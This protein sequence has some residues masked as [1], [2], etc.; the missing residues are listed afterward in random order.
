ML[1]KSLKAASAMLFLFCTANSYA[2]WTSASPYGFTVPGITAI[3]IN[4]S[5]AFP[6]STLDVSGGA[7]IGAGYAASGSV[8]PITNGLMVQ[9]KVAIGTSGA[10]NGQLDVTDGV[11]IGSSY[12]GTT[13]HNRIGNGLLVQ[14]HIGI[15]IGDGSLSNNALDVTGGAAIGSIYNPS[16]NPGGFIGNS[17]L[18]YP[19]YGLLV[20]GPMATGTSSVSGSNSIYQLAVSQTTGGAPLYRYG[21]YATSTSAASLSGYANIAGYFS[22]SNVTYTNG[23]GGTANYGL[24]VGNGSTI[25]TGAGGSGMD[26]NGI[27]LLSANRM[28]WIPSKGSFRVGSPGLTP[29]DHEWDDANIG[30]YTFVAG[31][32]SYAMGNNN[33][34][35]GSYVE[36]GSNTGCFIFGDGNGTLRNTRH[37]TANNQFLAIA[38]GGLILTTDNTSANSVYINNIGTSGNTMMGIGTSTPNSKITASPKLEVNGN[39]NVDYDLYLGQYAA[40]ASCSLTT[41]ASGAPLYVDF[42]TGKVDY[43]APSLAGGAWAIG[44]N[45]FTG[46]VVP[47][48]GISSIG[49]PLIL[50]TT[51]TGAGPYTNLEITSSGHTG[52]P[53]H[54]NNLPL[55]NFN[56][57]SSCTEEMF[58]VGDDPDLY[59]TYGPGTVYNYGDFSI[60]QFRVNKN[61]EVGIYKYNT[62]STNVDKNFSVNNDGEIDINQYSSGST[63]NELKMDKN[64]YITSNPLKTVPSTS[65][66]TAGLMLMAVNGKITACPSTAS[67][68]GGLAVTSGLGLNEPGMPLITLGGT[69]YYDANFYTS[70]GSG[71]YYNVRLDHGSKL[72][73]GYNETSTPGVWDV[74]PEKLSITGGAI[75][76]DNY[77][78]STTTDR[79]YN[80]SGTLM[81]NGNPVTNLYTFSNGI[82]NSSGSVG[83]GGSLTGNTLLNTT[84][85]NYPFALSNTS[86]FTGGAVKMIWMPGKQAF[87]AGSVSG[88]QWDESTNVGT[89]STAFG[90]NTIASGDGSFSA[91]NNNN[92]SGQYS[93]TGG[94]GNNASGLA[95]TAFGDGSTASGGASFAAG[96]GNTATGSSSVAMGNSNIASTGTSVALGDHNTVLG[97]KSFATGSTNN[98]NTGVTNG[99]ALGFINTVSGDLGFAAGSGNTASGASSVAIGNSNTSSGSRSFTLGESC[100]AT[101]DNTLATG[102]NTSAD[103]DHST[104]MGNWVSTYGYTG[105]FI[106]GDY[107][108]RG[109]TPTRCWADNQMMARFAGGYV[110]F[111]DCN[112]TMTSIGAGQSGWTST[113]DRNKKE[114]FKNLDGEKVLRSI[115]NMQVQEWSYKGRPDIRYIGTMAQDFHKEFPLL[116]K[117]SLGINQIDADGVALAGIQ[118]L[119]KRSCKQDSAIQSLTLKVQQG[120]D[121]QALKDALKQKDNELNQ[122]RQQLNDLQEQLNQVK[123]YL[124]TLCTMPCNGAT[125]NNNLSAPEQTNPQ[126]ATL[127]DTKA[128]LEPILYQNQPNPFNENTVIRYFLPDNK[129][130]AQLI[131]TDVKGSKQYLNLKLENYGN[132]QVAIEAGELSAGTYLYSLVVNGTI[133]DTKQMILVK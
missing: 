30:N 119:I 99:I 61:G 86:S 120:T 102:Y 41:G 116:G 37:N 19:T 25:F 84:S 73:L 109:P 76:L 89:N 81:W 78:P 3:G 32:G 62:T 46:S 75:Y 16:T 110:F 112:G 36:D 22:A 17:T 103:G 57:C 111:S 128:I 64:G 98:I 12:A 59:P 18:V 122:T 121:V 58:Y 4:T 70:D 44:G 47:T 50:G 85:S 29:L 108:N 5:G 130:S 63:I 52:L 13:G 105:S 33:V 92:S 69:L 96:N 97:E 45:S 90:Y 20:E 56:G 80:N 54:Y 83:L 82:T 8:T 34:V 131:V 6:R 9:G 31:Y 49:Q 123:A 42:T 129:S 106:I 124:G 23:G 21:L 107:C 60:S 53:A 91:C 40:C 132:S 7:I 55:N 126:K 10:P 113:S 2:Q 43:H 79:L 100:T 67:G 125:G 26:V 101:T 1:K 35:I 87:R 71:G 118:A 72:G 39:V 114:N 133:I 127:T 95:S 74:I 88:S 66:S 77:T 11:V 38:D 104:A 115:S 94:N 24:Y 15:G 51:K 48:L 117:D 28:V 27:S 65:Y 93:F 68:I 14:S